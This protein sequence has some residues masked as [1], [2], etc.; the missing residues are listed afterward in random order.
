M[1]NKILPKVFGWMFIGLLITFFTGY[2]VSLHPETM[3]KL[4]GSWAFIVVIVAELALVIFLS[5]RITKMK[6]ATAIISFI[7]I[8]L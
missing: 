2:Y 6:P 5:A 8:Q 4:F 3:L 7:I 1:T